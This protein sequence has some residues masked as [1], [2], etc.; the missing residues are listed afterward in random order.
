MLTGIV[1]GTYGPR[2]AQYNTTQGV[3][4]CFQFHPLKVTPIGCGHQPI[5][6]IPVHHTSLV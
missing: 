2:R 4:Y 1:P 3:S 5:M 6:S